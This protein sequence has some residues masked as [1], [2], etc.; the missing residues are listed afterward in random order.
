MLVLREK[1]KKD[2]KAIEKSPFVQAR[3]NTSYHW[4]LSFPRKI[5][6]LHRDTSS[7]Y[8]GG[9]LAVEGLPGIVWSRNMA[10]LSADGY[11]EVG[12]TPCLLQWRTLQRRNGAGVAGTM[13][14]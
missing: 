11:T 6:T 10:V 8:H 5:K 3:K 9:E 2:K 7:G 13:L 1:R 14:P 12:S 4:I